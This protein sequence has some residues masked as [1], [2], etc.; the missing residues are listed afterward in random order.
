[1]WLSF[2]RYVNKISNVGICGTFTTR[3]AIPLYIDKEYLD[4]YLCIFKFQKNINS[5][6]CCQTYP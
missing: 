1:M 3:F 4:E 2:K 6:I 5:L